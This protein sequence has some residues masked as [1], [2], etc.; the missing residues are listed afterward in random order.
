MQFNYFSIP[1]ILAAILMF[2]L[3]IMIRPYRTTPGVRYFS[4]LMFSGAVYSFFYVFELSAREL[5]LMEIFWKLQYTG[6]PFI[7]AFFLL[8]AVS[9]TRKSD[10]H[11]SGLSVPVLLFSLIITLLVLTNDFHSFFISG[12]EVNTTGAFPVLVFSAGPGYWVYQV[13]TMTALFSG[14]ALL[15]RMYISTSNLFRR[16]LGIILAGSAVPLVVY[17]LYLVGFFPRGLDAN[18]FSFAVTGILI[19]AGI[20]RFKLFSFAPLARN[21]LF[22]SIPD[23]VI[24]LDGYYRL[25]DINTPATILFGVSHRDTGR[26]AGEVFP[27]W[28][29]ITANMTGTKKVRNFEISRITEQKILFLDCVFNPLIDEH[30]TERG[31]MLVVHDVTKQR[32]AEIEKYESEEKFQIIFENA[33]VGVMYF[34]KNGIVELCNDYFLRIL[35]SERE[36]VEG[37]NLWKLADRRIYEPLKRAFEGKKAVFEGEYTSETGNRTAFLNIVLKPLI[38]K[39]GV[40]EGGLCIM[41]DITG[42]KASEE[43]IKNANTELERINAEKDRFFSI[44]A[45][46]LRSPFTAFLGYTDL[47]EE[48]I[49]TM[50]TDSIRSIA[51]SMK[52]S[53]NNLYGL[54]ENLLQWSRMQQGVV[55]FEPEKFSLIDKVLYSIEPLLTHANNKLIDVNY[56]IPGEY[57][58][59]TDPKMFDTIIR[60]LFTNAVKF[61]PKHG[62]IDISAGEPE[63]D[64]IEICFRDTG[65]GMNRKTVENLFRVDVKTSRSG[66]E[67]EQSTGLG[68]ILVKEF[69]EMNGGEIWVE[70]EEGKGSGF[71]IRLKSGEAADI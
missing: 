16:Q 31:Q 58:V 42:R 13:F 55:Y 53:A 2:M 64:Y 62:S 34:D 59:F 69:V 49:E 71:F 24:V 26:L 5:W 20:S 6:I 14:I 18:P 21:M 50:P 41:E 35:G 19:F 61:T 7:P 29:E 9:Y 47:L 1:V 40:V 27:D 28:P 70:S 44:L 36:R 8:F 68:L 25:I 37:F 67:G 12:A 30:G 22:D 56:D 43:S 15:F 63:K 33:P 66:T 54:L 32:T 52:E 10:I 46:D 48:S 51:T 23:G 39:S 57:T 38:S 17:I 45:H 65:I 60:N 11:Y 3:G 4:L